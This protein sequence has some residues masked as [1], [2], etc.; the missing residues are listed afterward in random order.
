MKHQILGMILQVRRKEAA[1]DMKK[2]LAFYFDQ[3]Y[4]TGCKTCQIACKDKN[5]LGPG[6]QYRKVREFSGGSFKKIGDAYIPE[7]YA[8]WISMSCNHCIDPACL[9]SCPVR[10]IHKRQDDGVVYIEQK[11]CIGCKRC[12][13]SCPYGAIQFNTEAVKAEKCDFCI[14]ELDKGKKPVCIS[15][16]PMRVLDCGELGELRE[17]YG[18]CSSI[19]GLPNDNITQP[20]LVISPHRAAGGEP[21]L[22]NGTEE[23]TGEADRTD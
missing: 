22:I 17:K 21:D 7:V 5:N 2:Q 14:D 12:V 11:E 18:S 16:C 4:C 10:A 6:R 23:Q 1:G 15:A 8:F 20:S 3:R 13:R 19:K 9:K